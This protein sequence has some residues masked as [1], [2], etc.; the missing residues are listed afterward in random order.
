M[1]LTLIKH[2]RRN[3]WN[4]SVRGRPFAF[5]RKGAGRGKGDFR[6]NIPCRLISREKIL[7][8]NQNRGK[9][10]LDWKKNSLWCIM[11]EKIL[12]QRFEKKILTQT[13]SPIPPSLPPQKFRIIMYDYWIVIPSPR[14]VT[15]R[16]RAGGLL[17]SILSVNRLPGK[18]NKLGNKCC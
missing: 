18:K 17:T 9:K 3:I 10:F 1:L 16:V 14:A 8:E 13:K 12:L 5:W 2:Q 11:L 6:I 15:G 4:L 7:K